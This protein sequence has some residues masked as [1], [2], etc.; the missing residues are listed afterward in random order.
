MERGTF[1]LCFFSFSL[2]KK[3]Y[4]QWKVPEP[5]LEP[6]KG[7]SPTARS[8][9]ALGWGDPIKREAAAQDPVKPRLGMGVASRDSQISVPS[10]LSQRRVGQKVTAGE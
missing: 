5:G 1:L 2:L 6:Y 10:S 7:M 3:L 8:L 4:F 9:T